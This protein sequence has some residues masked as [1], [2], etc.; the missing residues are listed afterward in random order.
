MATY[1]LNYRNRELDPVFRSLGNAWTK[2]STADKESHFFA[3]LDYEDGK[4]TFRK[5]LSYDSATCSIILSDS[6]RSSDLVLRLHFEFILRPRVLAN[7]QMEKLMDSIL[8]L[9]TGGKCIS[10]FGLFDIYD[11]LLVVLILPN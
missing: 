7:Q 3:T 2:V 11:L 6:L 1:L 5:V 4:D 9:V 10:Y 8:T